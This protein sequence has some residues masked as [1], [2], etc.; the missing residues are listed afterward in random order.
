MI[1]FQ[2]GVSHPACGLKGLEGSVEKV[3]KCRIGGGPV[4]ENK[5]RKVEQLK[6]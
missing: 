1:L 6:M 5:R 2:K 4:V 3:I